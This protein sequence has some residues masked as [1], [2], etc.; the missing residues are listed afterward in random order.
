MPIPATLE[1]CAVNPIAVPV[2]PARY[3]VLRISLDHLWRSPR[4]FKRQLPFRESACKRPPFGEGGVT[5]LVRRSSESRSIESIDLLERVDQH[6][7]AAPQSPQ[8]DDGNGVTYELQF[9]E[10]LLVA[11]L[12]GAIPFGPDIF[13]P[14]LVGRQRPPF[15]GAQERE[16]RRGDQ[17]DGAGVQGQRRLG[18]INHLDLVP[19]AP[20][21]REQL[22]NRIHFRVG[23]RAEVGDFALR[24]KRAQRRP[25]VFGGERRRPGAFEQP[26]E[27]RGPACEQIF[28]SPEGQRLALDALPV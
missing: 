17:D 8:R 19:F 15:G 7:R 28:R 1:G 5:R 11:L 3:R 2:K 14:N 10:P 6:G 26:N 13:M 21:C 23:R 18:E 9:L 25:Q 27:G 20:G 12:V 4:S 22:P 24:G 16:G